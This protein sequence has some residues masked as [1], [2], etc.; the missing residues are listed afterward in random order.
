[1]ADGLTI[2]EVA[3]RTGLSAYT[4]RYY[5]RAGL[6]PSVARQEGGQR[7][8]S[9]ESLRAFHFI[10]C[11]RLTGMPIREIRDYMQ[12][13]QAGDETIPQRRAM[14]VKHREDVCQQIEDLNRCLGQLDYKLSLYD[15]KIPSATKD[16]AE[17][18]LASAHA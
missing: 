18:E 2:Q 15:G 6:I 12:A 16:R 4:L 5:E 13:V 17:G 3:Q 10:T 11:L 8:Y 14:L 9:E 1:M 7:R